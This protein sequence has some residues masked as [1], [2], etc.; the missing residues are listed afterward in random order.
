MTQHDAKHCVP[1]QDYDALMIQM[2]RVLAANRALAGR[3]C[4]HG[5]YA[6]GLA[7]IPH[8]GSW[9]TG[10]ATTVKARTLR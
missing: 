3:T 8:T 10:Y 7:E 2:K 6:R 5:N 4:D 1:R 9:A